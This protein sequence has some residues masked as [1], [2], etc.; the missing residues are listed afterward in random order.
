MQ[1]SEKMAATQAVNQALAKLEAHAG[2]NLVT[3]LNDGSALAMAA[4]LDALGEGARGPLHGLPL[5]VKANIAVSGMRHDGACPPLR[6]N[7]AKADATVV[8]RLCDAG[9]I[10]V[11]S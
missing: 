6:D 7:V 8:Q 5:I 1:L 11:V 10:P 2:L 4:E 3:E 9:A